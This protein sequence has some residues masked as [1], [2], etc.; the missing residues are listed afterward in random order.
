MDHKQQ[1][2]GGIGVDPDRT[3]NI[4]FVVIPLGEL[5]FVHKIRRC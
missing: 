3:G 1:C 4:K 5:K 2:L